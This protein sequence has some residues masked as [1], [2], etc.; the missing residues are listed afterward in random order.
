ML[1]S[2]VLLLLELFVVSL[3]I[4]QTWLIESF[5]FSIGR[6]STGILVIG[7]IGSPIFFWIS[8][9]GN[10]LSRKYEYEADRYSVDLTENAQSMI[11]SLLKIEKEKPKQSYTASVV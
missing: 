10:I 8:P 11:S 2:S 5:G 6:F 9:I 3:L 1:F 7:L 4:N